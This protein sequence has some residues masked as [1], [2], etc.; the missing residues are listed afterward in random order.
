MVF[1]C[2]SFAIFLGLDLMVGLFVLFVQLVPLLTITTLDLSQKTNAFSFACYD[3]LCI[4]RENIRVFKC[5]NI[6][7][8]IHTL[9]KGQSLATN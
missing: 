5:F 6:Q 8:K 7:I 4:G 3:L 9:P 2:R 1:F